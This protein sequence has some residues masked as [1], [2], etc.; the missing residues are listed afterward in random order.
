MSELMPI[1]DRMRLA[2]LLAASNLLPEAY[3]KQPANVLVAIEYGRALG[4]EPMAAIQGINVIKGKPTASASLIGSLV[5]MAGHKLRVMA[6]S[7]QAV[8]EIIRKDDPDFVFRTVW[9]LERAASAGLNGDQWRKYPDAMLKARA[10]TE[11]ARD[12][13]P[14][15]LAGVQY[16][17]EE[18]GA[19][20]WTQQPVAEPADAWE[21]PNQSQPAYIGKIEGVAPKQS[22]GDKWGVGYENRKLP[23]TE[24]QLFTLKKFLGDY[25]QHNEALALAI[26]QQWVGSLYEVD[27][28]ESIQR[29][30]AS[31]MIDDVKNGATRLEECYQRYTEVMADES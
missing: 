11:C 12:A 30:D 16:T 24:K 15:V 28:W 4:L 22:L 6:D 18:L 1:N 2:E 29:Q 21:I 5:R 3:R 7:T 10:I 26:V 20:E 31:D 13:C 17:A 19:D 8:C 27:G 9:T 23:A 14:E 25:T